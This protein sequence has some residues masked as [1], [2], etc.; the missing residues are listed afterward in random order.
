MSKQ[1]A[2]WLQGAAWLIECGVALAQLVAF[3]AA[4]RRPRIRGPVPE[5]TAMRKLERNSTNFI[6]HSYVYNEE[7]LIKSGFVPPNLYNSRCED[8][9]MK[10]V[11]FSPLLKVLVEDGVGW[12]N[13]GR[14]DQ[15][16]GIHNK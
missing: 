1:V 4:G 2:K 9:N 14:K 8:D 16:W 7:K 6:Y 15:N 13:S 12:L 10:W 11:Y 3:R 5:R